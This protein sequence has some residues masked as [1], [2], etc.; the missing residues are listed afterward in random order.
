MG[1]MRTTSVSF[2]V[3]AGGPDD[4]VQS[5]GRRAAG[6]MTGGSGGEAVTYSIVARDDLTGELG[7]AVQTCMFAVG[8]LV[9]WARPGVG[10]VVSQAISGPAYGPRC[11]DALAAGRT[12]VDAL[13]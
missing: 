12:A 9:P 3:G 11:L 1:E 4:S 10:A 8:S 2:C 7:V 5:G 13:A 6:M